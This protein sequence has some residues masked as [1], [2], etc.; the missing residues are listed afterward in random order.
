M[1]HQ[2]SEPQDRQKITLRRAPFRA[3]AGSGRRL[4]ALCLLPLTFLLA[5]H[6]LKPQN[7]Q[8]LVEAG[9]KL[10]HPTCSNG[11]CH[12]KAGG[13]GGGP[14]LRG[15][16]FTAE[17]LTR[18]ISE[19]VSGTPM[20][21]FKD[22]F[23]KEQ[24]RQLVAYIRSLSNSPADAASLPS[25]PSEAAPAAKA[26]ATKSS[27]A[28]PADAADVRGDAA[29]GRALFFDAAQQ[30]SCRACH[31][32]QGQGGKL[33]PDLSQMSGKTARELFQSIIFP[34]TAVEV[35]YATLAITTRE[36]ER[37]V[38]LKREEDDETIKVFDASSLPPVSRTFQKA[39]V[40]KIERLNT[41]VMPA[42]YA[43][44][45]TLKQLLDLVAFL[46]SAGSAPQS[47]VSLKDLF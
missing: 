28:A 27:A 1:N 31:S 43:S 29:A 7:N 25:S 36:G 6:G 40:V 15:K 34:Q 10:F 2:T 20:R 13:G 11:Y 4:S 41:S 16:S 39:E 9:N 33:G 3:L 12:G 26:E 37:M 38:G 45:Y 32:F 23:T 8:S 30:W 35:A 24:I 17:Y 47:S 42:D 14:A 46:K 44:R 22:D 18:V 21:G 5:A 19:G